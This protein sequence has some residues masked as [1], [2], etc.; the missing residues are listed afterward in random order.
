MLRLTITIACIFSACAKSP[1]HVKAA[2]VAMKK[3]CQKVTLEKDVKMLGCG[4]F[5]DERKIQGF[6]ADF[7]SNHQFSKEDARLL[8]T[9]LVSTCVNDLN[10]EE[11]L[12]PYLIDAPIGYEQVSVSIGF[13]GNDR[14]PFKELSQIHLFENKIY[15][16]V[17]DSNQN[18]YI[19]TQSENLTLESNVASSPVV[20][21][22]ESSNE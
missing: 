2:D 17:Y 13:V 20:M 16:S 12:R 3:F 9:N 6:Y 10:L 14:K 11:T 21:E 7:E 4:G 22:I 19:C 15:Y 8:L 1:P 5:F 18:A